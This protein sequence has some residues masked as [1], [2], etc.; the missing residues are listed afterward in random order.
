MHGDDNDYTNNDDQ[1]QSMAK[2]LIISTFCNLRIEPTQQRRHQNVLQVLQQYR[3]FGRVP[4]QQQRQQRPAG[5]ITTQNKSNSTLINTWDQLGLYDDLD[6]IQQILNNFEN[7]DN[8]NPTTAILPQ[9]VT[10][11]QTQRLQVNKQKKEER[12]QSTLL[13]ANDDD[14]DT[15]CNDD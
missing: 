9:D 10:V 11:R 5:F 7:D 1:T 6:K 8:F 4:T 13:N 3:S 2:S 12:N 14:D 15:T